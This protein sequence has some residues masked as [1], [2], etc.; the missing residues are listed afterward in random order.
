MSDNR[1]GL[2]SNRFCGVILGMLAA[3]V[4]VCAAHA[5]LGAAAQSVSSDSGHLRASLHKVTLATHIR[6]ELTLPNGGSVHEF[7]NSQGQIF[8]VTWRGPG[9]PD[10]R[11]LLGP[12]FAD[13][14]AASAQQAA[15]GARFRR[16]PVAISRDD[17]KIQT[18]GHMGYFWGVAYLP[19]LLPPGFNLNDLQ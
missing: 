8:A 14:Q 15:H 17:L 10:L 16:I 19:A 3:V 2:C 12:H 1:N 4:P 6:H 7:A 18:G 5:G 11:Q 13:L 9:K